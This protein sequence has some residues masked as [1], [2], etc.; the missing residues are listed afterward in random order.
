MFNAASS[1]DPHPVDVFQLAKCL[2]VLSAGVDF[3][4][5]GHISAGSSGA[6][7]RYVTAPRTSELDQII[8]RCTRRE[9]TS[10]PSMAGFAR[11]LDVWLN[12]APP[13]GEPDVSELTARFRQTHQEA[14]DNQSEREAWEA[15]F[16]ELR[17]ELEEPFV[18]WVTKLLDNAGIR[19]QVQS[20]HEHHSWVERSRAMQ[21]QPE[22]T[23]DQIWVVGEFGRVEWPTKI[24]VAVGLDLDISGEFWCTGYVTWGDLEATAHRLQVDERVAP[25]ESIEASRFIADLQGDIRE[26][27]A[28]MLSQ[29]AQ[30]PGD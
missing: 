22:L 12:Y 29:L 15:R 24:A 4:P 10:R 30:G 18:E 11:E 8:D 25:I 26:A 5:Q 2:L 3:P 21:S 14:L 17:L 6:L 7:S 16:K 13:A 27:C 1:A 23:S 19:A 9:P 28:H 20:W